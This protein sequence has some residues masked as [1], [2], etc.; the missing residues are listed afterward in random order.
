MK[1]HDV[2]FPLRQFWK[3]IDATD[4]YFFNELVSSRTPRNIYCK[5]TKMISIWQ[6]TSES[7][8]KCN[9]LVRFEVVKAEL[10]FKP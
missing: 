1:L 10:V 4:S 2:V 7:E 5:S 9:I 6:R 8:K 3:A